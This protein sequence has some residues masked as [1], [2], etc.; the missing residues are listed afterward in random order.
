M[1]AEGGELA[2]LS[3]ARR[4]AATFLPAALRGTS[5]RDVLTNGVDLVAAI[6]RTGSR[7]FARRAFA[8]AT[9]LEVRNRRTVIPR[10]HF[11]TRANIRGIDYELEEP[12]GCI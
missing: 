5:V 8:V 9:E 3:R 2:L 12:V 11:G 6:S 10:R 4:N 7:I 1:P